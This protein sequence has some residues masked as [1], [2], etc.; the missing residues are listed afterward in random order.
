ML[1]W[2][3]S[4]V[5][6][7]MDIMWTVS[8]FVLT[9]IGL[10]RG[11]AG[12]PLI[13][14]GIE[15]LNC[16]RL[17]QEIKLFESIFFS[18]PRVCLDVEL[19]NDMICNGSPLCCYL[20]WLELFRSPMPHCAALRTCPALLPCLAAL[21]CDTLWSYGTHPLQ[22]FILL[23]NCVGAVYECFSAEFVN[24]AWVVVEVDKNWF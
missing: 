6:T 4:L 15:L 11:W 19:W 12:R 2:V 3:K 5:W 8:T 14:G 20:Q 10:P 21:P 13:E 16:V 9:W 24:I 17:E 7:Q 23:K 22:S 1:C 18:K